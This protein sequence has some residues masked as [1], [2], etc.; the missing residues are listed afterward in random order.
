MET[1]DKPA[2]T[3]TADFDK[4]SPTAVGQML[5]ETWRGGVID[6]NGKIELT[7]YTD[8]NLTASAKGTLHFVWRHGSVGPVATRSKTVPP[9]IDRPAY[10]A[11]F[12]RWTAEASIADGKLTLGQNELLQAG[13]KHG[14]EA[15][16]TL[17]EPPKV[18][19]AVPKQA[20]EKER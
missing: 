10:L 16:V 19:F 1:G 20:P 14:V 3:L 15:T 5:G 6:A 13:R 12:D 9:A 2:Y 4:L 11:H 17:A 7:G 8:K 18:S